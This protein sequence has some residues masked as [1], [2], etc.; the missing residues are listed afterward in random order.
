MTHR[1]A[2]PP[3]SGRNENT[4]GAATASGSDAGVLDRLR[5]VGVVY[6]QLFGIPDYARYL[7]HAAARH[8]DAPVLSRR[9]F[10][11]RAIEHKYARNG[12]RCC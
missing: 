7:A 2:D 8:P 3:A 9:E 12:P 5:R 4:V 10:C 1:K 11:A 6:R